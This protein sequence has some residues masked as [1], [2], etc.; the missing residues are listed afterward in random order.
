MSS[1]GLSNTYTRETCVYLTSEALPA[2][3]LGTLDERTDIAHVMESKIRQMK[4]C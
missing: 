3:V 1:S 4:G 2:S